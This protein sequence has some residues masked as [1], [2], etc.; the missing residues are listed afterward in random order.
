VKQYYEFSKSKRMMEMKRKMSPFDMIQN[1][2]SVT[3]FTIP[4]YYVQHPYHISITI[5][6]LTESNFMMIMMENCKVDYVE[7]CQNTS[8]Y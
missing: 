7:N 6:F 8:Y 4:A 1:N 5:L 2:I 3:L